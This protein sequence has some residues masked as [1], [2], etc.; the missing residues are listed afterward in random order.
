MKQYKLEIKSEENFEIKFNDNLNFAIDFGFEGYF[1]NDVFSLFVSHLHSGDTLYKE[2]IYEKI[3][4][5]LVKGED[6]YIYYFGDNEDQDK[7]EDEDYDDDE[8]KEENEEK[9]YLLKL[10][11]VII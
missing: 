7:D 8:D 11:I 9:K 3:K 10:V 6:L 2:N 4:T 5:K 1:L